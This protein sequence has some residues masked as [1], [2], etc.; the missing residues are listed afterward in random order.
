MRVGAGFVVASLALGG[1]TLLPDARAQ[2]ESE[3]RTLSV[4][5]EVERVFLADGG[6]VFEARVDT[7]ATST[8]IDARNIEIFEKNGEDWVRFEVRTNGNDSLSLERR[9]VDRVDIVSA[10]SE[11]ERVVVELDLCMSDVMQTVEVNL[12]NREN[13]TYRLL[14]GRDVLRDGGF[15]VN[16]A[17]RFSHEP[18]CSGMIEP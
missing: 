2:S 15:L 9:I 10:G 11:E 5:G 13:L 16:V 14:V 1:A 7:G 17:Q 3:R 6:L 8:S 18:S 4:V 12:A